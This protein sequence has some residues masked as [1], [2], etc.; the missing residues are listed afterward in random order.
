VLVVFEGRVGPDVP[1]E[2]SPARVPVLNEYEQY[3][4][5]DWGPSVRPV[6]TVLA[7][8]SIFVQTEGRSAEMAMSPAASILC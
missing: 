5:G 3:L 8:H 1:C 7:R 4:T 2:A 6:L